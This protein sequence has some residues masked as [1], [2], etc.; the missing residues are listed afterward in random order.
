[1]LDKIKQLMEMKKQAEQ[2]KQELDRTII[3]VQQIEGIRISISGSQ[4]IQN[5]TIDDER[6]KSKD[7]KQIEPY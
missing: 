3:D 5:I 7:K 1:M 6:L 2:I 4:K